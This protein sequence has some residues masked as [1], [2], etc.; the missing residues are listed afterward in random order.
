MVLAEAA[1]CGMDAQQLQTALMSVITR[2]HVLHKGFGFIDASLRATMA[3]AVIF[4]REEADGDSATVPSEIIA[5]LV[6]MLVD[7]LEGRSP[8][9]PAALCGVLLCL[10]VS[11]ANTMALVENPKDGAHSGLLGAIVL[12]LTISDEVIQAREG[13]YSFPLDQCRQGLSEVLLN[14]VLS[15]RTASAVLEYE[16]LQDA[17]ASALADGAHLTAQTKKKLD[18]VVFQ[19]KQATELAAPSPVDSSAAQHLMISYC[20]A[21]QPQILKI[22]ASLGKRAYQVWIDTEQMQGS[23]VDAMADAVDDSYCIAYALS[24]EYKEVRCLTSS[25]HLASY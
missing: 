25:S 1:R 14:L 11:D 5:K 2:G 16:G 21:Q 7:I 18:D 15:D 8:S 3:L 10:S 24:R 20:W 17:V 13:P 6:S 9:S 22:R 19:I 23:T 4:G 12:G